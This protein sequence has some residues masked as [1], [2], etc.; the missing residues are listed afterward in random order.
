MVERC[1]PVE[2]DDEVVKAFAR[3]RVTGGLEP[4][5]ADLITGRIMLGDLA[6]R[7]LATHARVQQAAQKQRAEQDLV[8]EV[9][10]PIMRAFAE[11]LLQVIE[12]ELGKQAAARVREQFALARET[13]VGRI[14]GADR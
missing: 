13:A 12:A 11:D 1:A 5:E 3:A 2:P 4:G 9:A 10:L 14:T 6:Q 7:M 8:L